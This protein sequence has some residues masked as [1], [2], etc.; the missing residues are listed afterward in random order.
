M[1]VLLCVLPVV[2]SLGLRISS[3]LLRKYITLCMQEVSISDL[4]HSPTHSLLSPAKIPPGYVV[5]TRGHMLTLPAITPSPPSSPHD[6]PSPEP[7]EL[8][9]DPT[10]SPLSSE[11]KEEVGKLKKALGFLW[12]VWL[13]TVDQVI[14]WLESTSADYRDVVTKIANEGKT[15]GHSSSIHSHSEESE[16]HVTTP[17][18]AAA[19]GAIVTTAEVHLP[20]VHKE[21]DDK[22]PA[23]TRFSSPPSSPS[24]SPSSPTPVGVLLHHVHPTAKEEEEA[25]QVQSQLKAATEHYTMRPMR[26]LQ[27]LYYWA[28]SHFEY[29]VFFFVILAI[30]ARR[31]CSIIRVC[32]AILF[33]WGLLS[34]PWPT[35]RFWITLMFYTMSILVVTYIYLCIVMSMTSIKSEPGSVPLPGDV[36]TAVFLWVLGV[37]EGATYL[38]V[39]IFSLL[40][41]MTI[42]VSQ[43][44]TEGKEEIMGREKS[45]IIVKVSFL[46]AIRS[47]EEHCPADED[48]KAPCIVY[49]IIILVLSCSM[50]KPLFLFSRRV[51]MMEQ[52]T[53]WSRR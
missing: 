35:K 13:D 19:A 52:D 23:K 2:F 26:L 3:L 14:I 47:L 36:T 6:T 18:E 16:D 22:Q 4:I 51:D 27:A 42:I 37:P 24:S 49:A 40:L 33:I 7:A 12:K 10:D 11:T 44:T 31:K 5:S 15:I 30:H 9:L 43:R 1:S 46:A 21:E 53:D 29:V 20:A 45:I 17:T 38:E 48:K 32:S 28:L 50:F 39:A 25:Y 8:E 41:L 34:I